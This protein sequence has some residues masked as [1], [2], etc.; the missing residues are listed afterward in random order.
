M[1]YSLNFDVI[2]EFKSI[3]TTNGAITTAKIDEWISQA[4]AYIDSR[5][6]LRYET[7]ITG[8]EALKVV[9]WISIGL[10]AQRIAH[11]LE[12]KSIVPVGDQA[13][14]KN[15]IEDAE[16][17]LEMIV[18]KQMTLSDATEASTHGGVKSYSND[19]TVCRTFDQTKD[20]W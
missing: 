8:T 11:V 13:I 16:K 14:P 19:N 12:T 4:D 3:D 1:A 17:K 18:N 6:G 15:L 20:Q 9:K 2:D 7:P 10:T 5:V